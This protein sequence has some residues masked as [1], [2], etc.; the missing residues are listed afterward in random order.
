MKRVAPDGGMLRR[1]EP[2]RPEPAKA[3]P[4]KAEPKRPEPMTPG[5]RRLKAKA[6]KTVPHRG[7]RRWVHTLTRINPGL[8]RGEK[9]E[10]ELQTRIRRNPHGP[11]E[12]AILGLKGGAGKTTA[13]VALGSLLARVRGDRILVLDADPGCGNLAERTGRTSAG[14]IADL[15][16]D[17]E[18]SNYNKVR[19]NTTVNAV[20]LEVL[21][22]EDYSGRPRAFGTD[23]WHYTADSVSKFYNVVLADCGAGMLDPATR[24][25]LATAAGVVIV[26][27]VSIDSARQ[28]ATALDWLRNN[29]HTDL[30]SRACIVLNHVTPKD[31][32]IA[33][34]DLA[35]RFEQQ[36]RPG[37]VVVLPWD[38][39]IASGNEIE[40]DRLDPVFRRRVLELAA[41]LS[42]DFER[43]GRR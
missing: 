31:P 7:W 15:L 16:S 28:A 25:V 9:Y 12:I 1:A 19:A 18:L 40:L 37:R 34:K 38:K 39:H 43:A 10:L 13:T 14:N 41:V 29:G 21:T 32:N 24:G 17:N 27:S 11:Y 8:S 20:N 35:K 2:A 22:A 33:A 42:D 30:M 23:A 26:T 36:V 5:P 4:A 6:P 3:E